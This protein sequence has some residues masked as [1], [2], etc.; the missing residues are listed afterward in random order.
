VAEEDYIGVAIMDKTV[1]LKPCGC[2]IRENSLGLPDFLRSMFRE[3]CMR[4]AIDLEN[5]QGMD[6]TFLGV[7]ADAATN[8][9]RH[10]GKNVIILNAGERARRE[11][12]TVGLLGLVEMADESVEPPE[13]LEMQRVDFL[14]FPDDSRERAE[15]VKY[16][17]EQLTKLN[18]ANKKKFGDFIQMLERELEEQ[19]DTGDSP[20][21]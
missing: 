5:C 12:A 3:G 21:S 8:L 15:Q 11:L 14:P 16:L 2:A 13:D 10:G 18:D 9:P 17:H 20:S 4:V 6:S 19:S 1:Y 7:V